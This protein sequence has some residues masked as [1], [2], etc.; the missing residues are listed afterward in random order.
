M[1][2]IMMF[3]KFD[4]CR[5]NIADGKICTSKFYTTRRA[6]GVFVVVVAT[7]LE[8]GGVLLST[9]S[10]SFLSSLQVAFGVRH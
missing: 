7:S 8:T 2:F 4:N 9:L 10:I 1:I 6:S 3:K 5:G